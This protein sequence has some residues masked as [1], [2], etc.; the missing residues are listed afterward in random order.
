MD[1]SL[2]QEAETLTARA[3][4]MAVIQAQYDEGNISEA[5]ARE[6][7]RGCLTPGDESTRYDDS[8]DLKVKVQ[9]A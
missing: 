5:D 8:G 2:K 6:L 4:R 1:K 7:L 9:N 3:L